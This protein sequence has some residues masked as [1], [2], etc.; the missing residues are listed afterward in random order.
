MEQESI[1][2]NATSAVFLDIGFKD[3]YPNDQVFGPIVQAFMAEW[4]A[5]PVQ[6]ERISLLLPLFRYDAGM[7]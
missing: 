7:L 3:H 1:V 2:A 5:A 6:K 4:S